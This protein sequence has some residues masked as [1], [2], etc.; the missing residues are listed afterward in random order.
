MGYLR[1]PTVTKVKWPISSRAD[2]FLKRHD[3]KDAKDEKNSNPPKQLN[4]I[5]LIGVF[6]L[7]LDLCMKEKHLLLGWISCDSSEAGVCVKAKRTY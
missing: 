3:F 4:L 2:A 1:K 7:N 5:L 6:C